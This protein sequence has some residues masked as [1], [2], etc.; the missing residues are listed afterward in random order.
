MLAS[1]KTQRHLVLCT[2]LNA[3]EISYYEMYSVPWQLTWALQVYQKYRCDSIRG[4]C[5]SRAA[6]G[7]TGSG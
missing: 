1:P 2:I 6:P 3:S 4:V 5:E 7:R